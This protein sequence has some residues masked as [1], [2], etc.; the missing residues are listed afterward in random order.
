MRSGAKILDREFESIRKL[1]QELSRDSRV[2]GDIICSNDAL[3]GDVTGDI[4]EDNL[5]FIDKLQKY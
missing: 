5:D 3:L 1:K 4:P 2:L